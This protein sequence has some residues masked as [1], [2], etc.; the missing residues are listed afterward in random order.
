[1]T[2]CASAIETAL[3]SDIEP[4]FVHLTGM[5]LQSETVTP[6]VQAGRSDCILLLFVLTIN[7]EQD[8]MLVYPCPLVRLLVALYTVHLNPALL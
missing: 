7:A 2:L 1:M 5:Q 4:G 6:E 8:A 3:D